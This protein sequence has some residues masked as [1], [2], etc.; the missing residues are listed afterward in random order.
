MSQS[1]TS[2]F[3]LSQQETVVQEWE[4]LSDPG[5]ISLSDLVLVVIGLF[6]FILP[7]LIMI[8]SIVTRP[9]R[10]G[11]LCLTNWRCLYL[12]QG[13]GWFENYHRVCT[14]DL[15]DIV[16]VH[17]CFEDGLFG[18]RSMSIKL[19]SRN[20]D[21][22]FVRVGDNGALNRFPILGKL[23]RRD[24]LGSDSLAVA[25]TLYSRLVERAKLTAQTT[26]G[27]KR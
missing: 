21:S 23:F 25:P 14:V 11:H 12:E 13:Q 10:T 26:S 22:M 6:F 17:S 27:F 2:F 7:G 8:I 18:G 16:A 24:S 4:V 3:K 9:S 5:R 20:E 15:D 1:A 19:H